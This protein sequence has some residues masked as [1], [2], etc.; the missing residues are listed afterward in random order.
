MGP[1][2]L[3]DTVFYVCYT[4]NEL[5]ELEA[6]ICTGIVRKISETIYGSKFVY[7]DDFVF[8]VSQFGK[9]LFSSYALAKTATSRRRKAS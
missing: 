1:V 5:C 3:G 2:K 4:S 6:H 8:D 9:S 7:I